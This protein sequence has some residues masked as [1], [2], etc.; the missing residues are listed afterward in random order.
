MAISAGVR[1]LYGPRFHDP[2]HHAITELAE[3]QA[4]DQTFMAIA[5]HVSPRMLAR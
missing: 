3:A 1:P 5:G 4:S 2:R